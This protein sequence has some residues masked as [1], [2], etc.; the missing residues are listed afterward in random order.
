M[1]QRKTYSGTFKA[2]VVLELLFGKKNRSI[3]PNN[4]LEWNVFPGIYFG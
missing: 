2:Q 4:S 1:R 3:N